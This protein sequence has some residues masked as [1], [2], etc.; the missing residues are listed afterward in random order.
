VYVCADNDLADFAA[1]DI[2]EMLKVGTGPRLRVLVQVDRSR[3]DKTL[4]HAIPKRRRVR[5][6]DWVKQAVTLPETNTGDPRALADFLRWGRRRDPDDRLALVLWD[7]GLGFKSLAED[8]GCRRSGRRRPL[9]QHRLVC[10]L[11]GDRQPCPDS[12]D[13]N[14]LAR[15]IRHGLAGDRP[16]DVLGFDACHMAQLEV[17]YELR[18]LSSV[19]VGS[20]EE[21]PGEG[22]PFHFLLL[23]LRR[24][25]DAGQTV[26]PETLA[27]LAARSYIAYWR[28]VQ[29]EEDGNTQ[30]VVRAARLSSLAHA[31][32]TLGSALR[33]GLATHG[34]D[35]RVAVTRGQ[36][37]D[38]PHFADLGDL[39][40]RLRPLVASRA[41]HAAAR[42]VDET[43]RSAVAYNGR[44]GSGVGRSTG[45]TLYV[46]QDADD[47]RANRSLYRRLAFHRD[48]PDW[49]AF[50]E[51][52]HGE[53]TRG[54]AR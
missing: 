35:I 9:R 51:A 32:A 38:E 2:Q 30:S 49:L 11:S 46:P 41:I 54:K 34:P 40:R 29:D 53:E 22:W 45:L 48:H 28:E 15:G 20:E 13:I 18:D 1:L 4:R 33:Q 16:L 44:V 25:L 14:E 31:T 26:T 3:R 36:T 42:R 37:Y 10:S 8:A 50:L 6:A 52:L 7:H 47:L 39:A 12:L 19:F 27:R 5:Y 24:R 23:A 17:L 43:L 21:E